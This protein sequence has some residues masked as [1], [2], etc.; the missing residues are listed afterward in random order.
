MALS[1][2][3]ELLVTGIDQDVVFWQTDEGRSFSILSGHKAWVMA[4]TFSPDG[5]ILASGSNDE[6]I[7][8]WNVETGQC[9]KTLRGHNSRLPVE[10]MIQLFDFGM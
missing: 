6:T 1:P 8:L 7:R 10:A 3:G 2:N 9:L 5:K 4:V